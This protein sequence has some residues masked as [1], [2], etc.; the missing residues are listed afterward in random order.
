MAESRMREIQRIVG[1]SSSLG[2]TIYDSM[3]PSLRFGWPGSWVDMLLQPTMGSS[4]ESYIATYNSPRE[5]HPPVK[6]RLRAPAEVGFVL[7]RVPVKSLQQVWA[8]LEIVREQAWINELLQSCDWLPDVGDVGIPDYNNFGDQT[9]EALLTGTYS[10]D[11]LPVHVSIPSSAPA[12]GVEE[13]PPSRPM[14][15]MVVPLQRR[16]GEAMAP[17]TSVVTLAMDPS[18]PRGVRVEVNNTLVESLDEPVRRG[19]GLG[20]GGRLWA[21]LVNG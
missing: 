21:G 14:L 2:S 13:S 4:P 5:L 9:L 20:I 10:P 18:R 12:L 7:S 1:I 19:G 11:S 16:P 15:R 8:I 3:L 6:L 17:R